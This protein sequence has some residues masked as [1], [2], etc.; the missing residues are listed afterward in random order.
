MRSSPLTL[1]LYRPIFIDDISAS[2]QIK[3]LFDALPAYPAPSI[4]YSILNNQYV[5]V[6]LSLILPKLKEVKIIEGKIADTNIRDYFD[7]YHPLLLQFFNT[8]A[9]VLGFQVNE[10]YLEDLPTLHL[11]NIDY[12]T[13]LSL[14]I[15]FNIDLLNR[16]SD[17]SST[18]NAIKQKINEFNNA[19][20]P[21]V[22]VVEVT[23]EYVSHHVSVINT[24]S[25]FLHVDSENNSSLPSTKY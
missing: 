22:Q 12:S 11:P 19:Y 4:P 20:K 10:T 14:S 3:D 23:Y 1:S 6:F 24:D 16:S 8:V 15:S 7:T 25:Y 5:I 17:S 9:I 18:Y 13:K 2:K 21:I